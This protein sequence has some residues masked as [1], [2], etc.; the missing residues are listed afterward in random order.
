MP[1]F[2]MGTWP[3]IQPSRCCNV[4]WLSSSSTR[5]PFGMGRSVWIATSA[6]VPSTARRS[7]PGS[8]RCILHPGPR[9]IVVGNAHVLHRRQIDHRELMRAGLHA[10]GFDVV[11]GAF[12]N[13]GDHELEPV[14]IRL[15][16]H[17]GLFP[18]GCAAVARKQTHAGTLEAYELRAD[19]LIRASPHGSV[20]RAAPGCCKRAAPRLAGTNCPRPDSPHVPGSPDRKLPASPA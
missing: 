13:S 12:R 7:P 3:T 8:S 14:A 2:W 1:S 10:A 11:L 15:G 18:L 5:T 16:L 17:P 6:L 19:E 9:G 4:I 20:A